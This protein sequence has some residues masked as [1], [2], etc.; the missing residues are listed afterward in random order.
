M[1]EREPLLPVGVILVALLGLLLSIAVG[2]A[3]LDAARLASWAAVAAV[4]VPAGS[5]L[6]ARG[7]GWMQRWR[8][9]AVAIVIVVGAILLALQ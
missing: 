8:V 1:S 6:L 5:V 4:A 3:A 9:G 2:T 7:R